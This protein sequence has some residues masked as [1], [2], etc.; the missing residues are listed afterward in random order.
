MTLEAQVAP[1][2]VSR[3][4]MSARGSVCIALPHSVAGLACEDVGLSLET[5]TL[6]HLTA[7]EDREVPAH[8]G[9]VLNLIMLRYVTC[10]AYK[11]TNR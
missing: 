6:P 11:G 9:K 4:P 1:L 10:F 5:V 2:V 8:G 7:P 3:S